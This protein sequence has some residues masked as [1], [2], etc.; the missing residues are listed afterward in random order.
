MTELI[1]GSFEPTNRGSYICKDAY[2]EN[3]YVFVLAKTVDGVQGPKN[4]PYYIVALTPA[5]HGARSRRGNIVDSIDGLNRELLT[6]LR[7]AT[8]VYE[9]RTRR[10]VSETPLSSKYG[11]FAAHY[12]NGTRPNGQDINPLIWFVSTN[13]SPHKEVFGNYSHLLTFDPIELER[14]KAAYKELRQVLIK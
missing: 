6:A 3:P 12:D 9:A 7:S 4:G 8:W 11:D 14:A 13:N 1:I 10:L 5:E 2:P